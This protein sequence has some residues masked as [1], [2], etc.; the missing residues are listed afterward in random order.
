MSSAPGRPPE[1]RG[2]FR[3]LRPSLER[4]VVALSEAL[5]WFFK[6]DSSSSKSGR[7]SCLTLRLGFFATRPVGEG[8]AVGGSHPI[9][10]KVKARQQGS[11]LQPLITVQFNTS[12]SLSINKLLYVS[13][14]LLNKCVFFFI[15]VAALIWFWWRAADTPISTTAVRR[16]EK[17]PPSV[18]LCPAV[19]ALWFGP[20]DETWRR[21]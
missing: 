6:R 15:S 12:Q 7:C 19:Q 14:K 2:R 13:D 17:P 8:F 16:S 9:G 21:N 10:Y 3:R 18:A 1:V 4:K 11:V 5:C 20:S